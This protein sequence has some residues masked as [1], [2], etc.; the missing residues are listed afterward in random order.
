MSIDK[1]KMNL[2]KKSY[3]EYLIAAYGT[4]RAHYMTS[5]AFRNKVNKLSR[6]LNKKG[7]GVD[8]SVDN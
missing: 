3:K 7:K 1:D 4:T 2:G 8:N 5:A 6:N